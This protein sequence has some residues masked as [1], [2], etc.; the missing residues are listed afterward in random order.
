MHHAASCANSKSFLWGECQ[1]D[2]TFRG[3]VP[4]KTK[5]PIGWSGECLDL[6]NAKQFWIL[7]FELRHLDS[8][9]ME[10]M[11]GFFSF[12]RVRWGR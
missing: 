7:L 1:L 6:L 12:V 5:R 10:P 9:A 2:A 3:H 4:P 11:R 8:E